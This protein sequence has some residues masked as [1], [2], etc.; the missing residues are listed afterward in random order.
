MGAAFA[1]LSM[2]LFATSNIAVI[3]GFDGR[4]RSGGA[5]VSIVITFLLSFA[6]WGFMGLSQGWPPVTSTALAWF[7]LAGLLTIFFGRVFLY[8]S[9][10]HLGAVKASAIKRLN[11]FFSVLLGVLLLGES[12]S[13][14]LLTGMALICT[15]FYVLVRETL[16][17]GHRPGVRTAGPG[18]LERL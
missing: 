8:A 12:L 18:A 10:Q 17:S 14:G 3:R 5:F 13:P 11:P 4:T 16:R 1:V 6:I 7:A 15:S 9:I 2:T